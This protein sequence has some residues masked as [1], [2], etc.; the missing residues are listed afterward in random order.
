MALAWVEV[1]GVMALF[2]R[3]LVI[4]I[5]SVGLIFGLAAP[6]MGEPDPVEEIDIAEA[7][8]ELGP[9]K[10]ADLDDVPAEAPTGDF[11]GA[12]A[13]EVLEPVEELV[14]LDNTSDRS[15]PADDVLEEFTPK[16]NGSDVV[17]MSE[18]ST[19]YELGDGEH[20]T[21][22][23]ADPV[24]VEDE[25]GEWV[26]INTKITSDEDGGFEVEDHPLSPDFS[27][28]STV[29]DTVSVER[30][31]YRVS[32]GLVG[33]AKRSARGP[34]KP[35]RRGHVFDPGLV[36][37]DVLPGVDLRYEVEADSV[38][39]ALIL[40][41]AP[42]GG[43]NSWTWRTDPDGLT[44]QLTEFDVLEFV[45]EDGEVIVHIPVPVAWD[46]SGEAGVRAP[47][48]LNPEV[49]LQRAGKWW[50]FTLTVDPKWLADP[51]RV[52]PVTVDPTVTV[53]TVSKWSI[54]SDG[55][56]RTDERFLGNTRENST[57]RYWRLFERFNYSQL[58]GKQVIETRLMV[59]Y[60]GFGTPSAR[61]G[62]VYQ[63]SSVSYGGL[64]PQLGSYGPITT[65]TAI[66]SGNYRQFFA[67]QFGAGDYQTVLA[68]RGEEIPGQY[69]LKSVQTS[70]WFRW[71]DYPVPS[72]VANPGPANNATNVTLTPR[73]SATTTDPN[74]D[75]GAEVFYEFEIATS[76]SFGSTTVW[77][78]P[79][80]TAG[81]TVVPEGV[82]SGGTK[83]FWRVHTRDSL[84]GLL[85]QSTE[86]TSGTW[87]FTTQKPPP[88]PTPAAGA[89]GDASGRPVITTT[90]PELVVHSVADADN[91]PAGPKT[92]RYEF[93]VTTG[94]DGATGQVV[95]S[96]LLTA[97]TDGLVRWTVPAG[98]LTD[99]GAYSWVVLPFDGLD[100]N[101]KPSWVRNF[102]VD[103]RLGTS[104]PSPMDTAGVVTTNL[105]NGN[106][107]LS[108][109]S[110]TIDT[111]GGPIGMSFGYNSLHADQS[112]SGLVGSYYSA[113][114]AN[115]DPPTTTAAWA[116]VGPDN[117]EPLLTRTD[118]VVSFDWGAGSP[119][120]G[121]E[122]DFFMARWTGFVRTPG[123]GLYRFGVLHDDGARLRV[124]G[125]LVVDRWTSG[126]PRLT[127]GTAATNS[128][129]VPV[130]ITVDM[131]EQR[132]GS[133][134][135][136]WVRDPTGAEYP[137]PGSW[138]SQRTSI[139]PAGWDSS[140]PLAG[141][142]TEWTSA[143]VNDT[144]IVLTDDSGSVTTFVKKSAGGYQA[145]TGE[146]GTVSL[147]NQDRQV[148]YT[149][150]DGT[151]VVFAT[152][153]SVESAT[154]P[155]DAI[156]PAAPV[157]TYH[158]GRV[159]HVSD[160]VSKNGATFDRR[161][162]YTYGSHPESGTCP[163]VASGFSAAPGGML[164]KITYPGGAITELRYNNQ[165]QLVTILDPGAERTD[166]VYNGQGRI[167]QIVDA[168]AHYFAAAAG[169]SSPANTLRTVVTYDGQGR[170]T[171]V[172]EPA[173]NGSNT[174]DQPKT[175]Y[176]YLAGKTYVDEAGIPVADG[177]TQTVEYDSAW[178]ST[179]VTSAMGLTSSQEWD[180][181]R[182]LVLSSTDPWGVR[183]T[184]IYDPDT[185]RETDTYGPAPASC[186]GTDRRPIASCQTTVAH[187][188]TTYDAQLPGL[189]AVWYANQ[190]LAGRPVS[191][192]H[193]IPGASGGQVNRN[194]GTT[195]P[196]TGTTAGN[197]SLRLNGR[198]KFGAAGVYEFRTVADDGTRVWVDETNV[199]DHWLHQGPTASSAGKFTTTSA[200]VSKTIRVE[201]YDATGPAQLRLEWKTPGS[202]T[203]VSVPGSALSPD[204]GLETSTSSPDAAPAGVT[205]VSGAQVPSESTAGAAPATGS[206]VVTEFVYDSWG[207]QVGSKTGDQSVWRCTTYDARGRVTKTERAGDRTTTT[208]YSVDPSR[209][210]V[211]AVSDNKVTGSTN[212]GTVTTVT[213]LNGR[214]VSYTDVWGV[215]TTS[216]YVPKTSRL[217]SEVTTIGGQATTT[218]FSYNLDGDVESV[219]VNG[220]VVADPVYAA[221]KLLGSVSYQNGSSLGSI[222]RD[223]AGRES[224][225]TW[226][227]AGS[228][229]QVTDQVV[230]SRK[231]KVMR[232]TTAR[233][234]VQHVSVFSYDAAGRLVKAVVPRHELT[235][236]FAGS[237]GC[238]V[239]AGAGRN[240]NRTRLTDV[241]DGNTGVAMVKD[242]CYDHAD[243]LMSTLV[244][245][246]VAGLNSVTD[247]L[248]ANE[249][250]YDARGNTVKLGAAVHTYDADD[251]HVGS[252]VPGGAG[253]TYVRDGQDRVV[254]RTTTAPGQAA[255]V[256]RYVF[257]GD[258]DVPYAT[259]NGAG[260]LTGRSWVLPGGVVLDI[261]NTTGSG[262][263]WYWSYPNL[264]GHT[265]TTTTGA[266]APA[267]LRAYDPFGQPI[268]PVTGDIGTIS[269]DDSAQAQPGG[270]PEGRTGWHGSAGRVFDT[271][272]EL[273]II[274]MGARPYSPALGRFLTVDPV[275]GGVDNDYV[276][277]PDPINDNDLSGEAKKKRPGSWIPA[278]LR[279]CKK[280]YSAS[281]KFGGKAYRASR[282]FLEKQ[283]L[284]RWGAGR[285]SF[286]PAH[287][288][289]KKMPSWRRMVQRTHLHIERRG[290]AFSFH[291]KSGTGTL[292]VGLP[293][294]FLTW[295]K[296]K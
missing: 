10:S 290:F 112:S 213:D 204:Y 128:T 125:S 199:V 180:P 143:K 32:F 80:S 245:N 39:E 179:K 90:T 108:F 244:S 177:H 169:Q 132:L 174:N 88:T 44:P 67:D 164:C 24:R 187:T 103:Q 85:G 173:P 6:V 20:V 97:G 228:G 259:L 230:R 16:R 114:D 178:R 232:S 91:V 21:V 145:P 286:G 160:P 74:H 78:S 105:A 121:V 240:G 98:S 192:S 150:E 191:M 15:E 126:A 211:T 183:N 45:D 81:E 212:N 76:N 13:D 72:L 283:Q 137:V 82:L 236:E 163:T 269:A 43:A 94:G 277:P 9:L 281:K 102:T 140:A 65:D 218:A 19:T 18:F 253:V 35:N 133:S 64:G 220:A 100:K 210:M 23:S 111:L 69:T 66:A 118:P 250:A 234:G 101:A 221:N 22:L 134:V 251:R 262:T 124:G 248:A 115:G 292:R 2:C 75:W 138:L 167:A 266:A 40:G 263:Q 131:F 130:S 161:V 280:A 49:E 27:A 209:G 216:T 135:Q 256:T 190:R 99:G 276:Y 41:E 53:G 272:G 70:L 168:D 11:V 255:V 215:T 254:Q 95:S 34:S 202:S 258:G 104:G 172:T 186:F 57:N 200:G 274:Q 284:A 194:W 61:A 296:W 46:S 227:F 107:A 249:V 51:D 92:I 33:A 119:A 205:G 123:S 84:D 71:K 156:K 181:V 12:L 136:L 73:L 203:F 294:G 225:Q 170:V 295:R 252:S 158:Q 5:A 247:G 26:D 175:T 149:D 77:S 8:A 4:L 38:K 152:D 287:N 171:S 189:N 201:Y 182:D 83:Y 89:V 223:G 260:Q 275:E 29:G 208:V 37:A 106:A 63:A 214:V 96:G 147:S 79:E 267:G 127:W 261:R 109:A 176:T 268:D 1:V 219:S 270:V 28:E 50:D 224:G 68:F 206:P 193:G 222:V 285:I 113:R 279:Y 282:G 165:G 7:V 42:A 242:Y 265:V 184:T 54:K 116:Q 14:E 48:L 17:E 226:S 246:P 60:N 52:Y 47:A 198:V 159:I 273:A 278:C 3:A 289:W 257:T 146:Y 141:E 293:G 31:G 185:D 117:R 166:C 87:S 271:T 162:S 139:L 148:T 197:W 264:L 229:G 157:S 120:P 56:V 291:T 129:G 237:G 155:E 243:R 93:K 122:S 153:G 142:L 231:G 144:S 195:A 59:G 62:H 25:D 238:G 188:T 217:A 86:R 110:P 30:D 55:A 239:S 151:V 235:Y 58:V 196:V 154:A 233:G 288:H 241:K 36:Y 207:R